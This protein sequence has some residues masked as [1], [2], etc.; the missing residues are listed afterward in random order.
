[1]SCCGKKRTSLSEADIAMA[2]TT[3]HQHAFGVSAGSGVR[4]LY[5]EYVGGS[6][7][8]VIGQGTGL[9]YRFVGHGARAS[10]D[11][12]DRTSLVNIPQLREVIRY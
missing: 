1:M 8:T 3:A 6:I 7:L 11:A 10:V 4:G 5:F 9:Q 2:A 12:R